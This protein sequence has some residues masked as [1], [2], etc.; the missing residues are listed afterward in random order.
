MIV[1]MMVKADRISRDV[2]ACARE[3]M[4][5]LCDGEPAQIGRL[6]WTLMAVRMSRY[7]TSGEHF[8]LPPLEEV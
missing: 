8:Q 2:E 4:D 6:A 1:S 5:K 7:T 3:L